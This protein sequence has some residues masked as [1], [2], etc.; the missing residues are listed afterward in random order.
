MPL[1][2]ALTGGHG[3]VNVL[4]RVAA[5][6]GGAQAYP[7]HHLCQGRRHNTNTTCQPCCADGIP[8]P[9]AT[10]IGPRPRKSH[11]AHSAMPLVGECSFAAAQL[12]ALQPAWCLRSPASAVG[13]GLFRSSNGCICTIVGP[14]LAG[15]RLFFFVSLFYCALR[16]PV[17]TF[18]Q[19]A[20]HAHP[21][22][23]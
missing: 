21:A 5:S 22:D 15:A 2:P 3:F 9:S 4:Y 14:N 13:K 6:A 7:K 12:A 19:G 17:R 1:L 11:G 20:R 8:S 16:M 10:A 23:S 18:R